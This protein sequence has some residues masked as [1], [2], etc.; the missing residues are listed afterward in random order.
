MSS[1]LPPGWREQ[2]EP[3]SGRT[4]YV[5]EQNHTTQWERPPPPPPLVVENVLLHKMVEVVVPGP[6]GASKVRTLIGRG[7]LT[8][9]HGRQIFHEREEGQV[10]TAV[11]DEEPLICWWA[12][13]SM[14]GVAVRLGGLSMKART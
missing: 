2:V 4:F 11:L 7:R 13:P 14:I 5:D 9:E 10:W 8:I 3:S 12:S 6:G 1:S